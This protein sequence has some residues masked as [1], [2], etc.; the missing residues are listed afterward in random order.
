MSSAPFGVDCFISQMV[1]KG[2]NKRLAA[3]DDSESDLEERSDVVGAEC[4]ETVTDSDDDDDDDEEDDDEGEEKSCDGSE[5][6]SDDPKANANAFRKLGAASRLAA[7]NLKGDPY[8]SALAALHSKDGNEIFKGVASEVTGIFKTILNKT[9]A[10]Q[11][12]SWIEASA[13]LDPTRSVSAFAYRPCPTPMPCDFDNKVQ[14]TIEVQI[15]LDLFSVYAK[16]KNKTSYQSF[17]DQ[18]DITYA[19]F[20][21]SSKALPIVLVLLQLKSFTHL[22]SP[23]YSNKKPAD[24]FVLYEATKKSLAAM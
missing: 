11:L 3:V 23:I 14:A 6:G 12:V 13:T 8:K 18:Q 5:S 15:P 17:I 24:V 21:V 19:R 1:S 4:S 10:K 7:K 2:A 20:N 16:Q 22:V 9:P